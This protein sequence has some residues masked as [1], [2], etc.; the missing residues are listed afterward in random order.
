MHIK[1]FSGKTLKEAT[2]L[3]KHELGENAIILNTKK[4]PMPGLLNIGSKEIYE[5]TAAIDEDTRTTTRTFAGDFKNT[6]AATYSPEQSDF[7]DL[8]KVS[9]EFDNRKPHSGVARTEFLTEIYGLKDEFSGLKSKMFE[10][11]DQIKY[12]HIPAFPD[13]F[14][15]EY[16]NLVKQGVDDRI[17]TDLINDSYNRMGAFDSSD[18]GSISEKILNNISKHFL[19]YNMESQREGKPKIVALVGPT[20]VGKTTTIAKLASDYK[21]IKKLNIGLISADTFRIGAI[22]QLR[23]FALIADIPIQV[24][25]EPS[26]VP[27]AINKFVNKD[28]IFI[29]TIGRSQRKRT[30]LIDLAQLLDAANADEVH[31]VISATTNGKEIDDIINRFKIF[32]PSSLIFSKIDEAVS[33]GSIL[34]TCY[35]HKMP[36]SYLT[37][38]QTVP[39][40]IMTANNSKIAK[41]IYYGVPHNV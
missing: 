34:N 9:N 2:Y 12:S 5:I 29:D 3:M 23:T 14:K 8:K 27:E 37:T 36:V 16:I 39:D 21:L 35:H 32:R 25:Y 13:N 33:I 28:I 1:K 19:S 17:V 20:G 22:E 10:I 6:L 24:V 11:A 15:N 30:E 26:D 38:G 41:M 31:L 40:D 18:L 7:S 4:V